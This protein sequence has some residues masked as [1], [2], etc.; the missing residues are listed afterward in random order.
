MAA[1][2]VEM[3]VSTA[4]LLAFQGV[5]GIEMLPPHLRI[6][7]RL[8]TVGDQE[9][10]V[11]AEEREA[12]TAAGILRDGEPDRDAI[13]LL[14]SLAYPDTE[15]NITL[16][17]ADRPETFVCLA[18]SRQLVAAAARCG[19]E[20]TIDAYVGLDEDAL[21]ELVA[22]TFERYLFADDEARDHAVTID[23]ATVRLGEVYDVMCRDEPDQWTPALRRAGVPA[24]VAAALWR[25]ETDMVR[26]GE[27]VAYINHE[28][29]RTAGDSIV[30]ATTT[31]QDAVL[32]SFASDSIGDRWLTVE[33]Y[34]TA[35]M[36]RFILA[37]IRSVPDRAWFTH[38]RTD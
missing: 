28:N 24:D 14:R 38:A 1:A 16:G 19:D 27:V 25:C 13:L 6:R 29:G 22:S 15:L 34:E 36:K 18:R 37:T 31:P 4:A 17:A 8:V 33:P 23:G 3:T 2:V 35:R 5:A 10:P 7:P 20:V 12:L 26:R 11:S 9:V 32:T 21:V 30:R